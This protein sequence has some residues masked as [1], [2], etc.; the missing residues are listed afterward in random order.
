MKTSK[1]TKT[2]FLTIFA[3]LIVALSSC[4]QPECKHENIAYEI[5]EPTHNDCGY[6]KYSCPDCDYS[7]VEQYKDPIPHSFTKTVTE[8]TC[9]TEG[10]TLYKCECGYSYMS[11][12]KAPLGHS[13]Q[14]TVNPPTCTLG[15][16]TTYSCKRC[17]NSYVSDL[18]DAKGHTYETEIVAPTCT[19][20]GY[21]VYTCDCG[22]SYNDKFTKPL[23]HTF[24]EDVTPPSCTAEGFTT[25]T[26]ECGY[27]FTSNYVA[28]TEHTLSETV[29]PASC[30][31]QGYTTHSCE[32]GYTFTDTY[33]PPLGHAYVPEVLSEASCTD[34]G[35]TE[36]ACTCGESYSVTVE[37]YGHQYKKEVYMPTLSDMGYTVYTC[38]TCEHTYTGDLSFYGEIVPDAYAESTTVFAKGIDVS[39]HN[40][41]QDSDGNYISLDWEKIKNSGVSYVIIRIADAAVGIDPTFEKSYTEAKAAGLDVGFYF[42]TRATNKKEITLE[43]NLVLSALEGKQFEYPVYLDLEDEELRGL[44]SS[45]LGEMCVTFFTA[46]QRAGY[47][48]G[49]YVNDEWL[50]NV[51]DTETAL[52]RFDIWYARYLGLEEGEQAVWNEETQG[53][54]FGMWQFTDSGMIEGVDHT[55]FDFNYCYKD[56]P[57]II[58][59]YGFNGYEGDLKFFDTDRSFVWVTYQGSIK[60]RSKSDYFTT[61]EYDS[62]LDVIGYAE[63]GLRFEVIEQNELY[64]AIRYDGNTAYISANPEYVSFKGLYIS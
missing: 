29:T 19:S 2:V 53:S 46:L 44:G 22:Y 39:Y 40:Y 1:L 21:T 16:S 50:Y 6:T 57:L 32:C 13:Y 62:E 24:S 23:E 9:T 45:I 26:C 31:A 49:L 41:R 17:D 56:Y 15:G 54:A 12:V 64:T 58:K 10:S 20:E 52:S 37:P 59:E 63:Y 4:D 38:E 48:T 7:Y 34:V 47:Y 60:I 5:V 8:P 35:I 3:I 36:Y 25:Y 43:A 30:T 61:E 14:K 33:T 27:S 51:I 55:V 18:T 11:D 42:Y 28:P